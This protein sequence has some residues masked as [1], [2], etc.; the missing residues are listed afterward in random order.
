VPMLLVLLAAVV[1]IDDEL[2]IT[3]SELKP[4]R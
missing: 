4:L 2:S 3:I 1:G